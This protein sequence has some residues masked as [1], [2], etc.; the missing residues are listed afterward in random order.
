MVRA[1]APEDGHVHFLVSAG[2]IIHSLQ[3]L[4]VKQVLKYYLNPLLVQLVKAS[5]WL[6]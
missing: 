5:L 2:A 3:M 6:S 4:P 1:R